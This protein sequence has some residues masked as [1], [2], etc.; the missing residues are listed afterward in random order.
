MSAVNKDWTGN[1]HSTFSTLGASSHTKEDRQ[2]ND[3][4]A[5]D[6]VAVKYLL[7][8]ESFKKVLEPSCGMGHISKE[9]EK[10]G[11]KVKSSDLIDYGFGK[12]KDFF[13]Y[14][15]WKG[16]IITN[17]PYKYAQEFVEHSMKIIKPNRKIALFLKLQFLEGKKRKILFAKYPPKTIYVSSSRIKC[18][19]NGDFDNTGTSAVAYAWYVWEKGFTGDPIIKWIN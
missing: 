6:P 12:V 10:A 1:K 3:F 16:D 15:K 11:L 5:T 17:P 19:K 9:L 14:E 13:T 2:I 8:V 7:E 18:A 4:Y